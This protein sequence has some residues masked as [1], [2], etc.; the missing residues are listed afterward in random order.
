MANSNAIQVLH[1][2]QPVPT[3]SNMENPNQNDGLNT[4]PLSGSRIHTSK[5]SWLAASLGN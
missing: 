2:M 3:S 1:P 5:K 4:V